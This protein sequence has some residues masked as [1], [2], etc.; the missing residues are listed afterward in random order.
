MRYTRPRLTADET[1]AFEHRHDLTCFT[2]AGVARR[3]KTR[4]NRRDRR[5]ARAAIRAGAED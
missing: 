1:D 3:T 2:R 4:A 5:T